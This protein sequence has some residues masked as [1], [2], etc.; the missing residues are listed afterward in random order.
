MKDSK[1][2]NVLQKLFDAEKAFRR[3]RENV[4]ADMSDDVLLKGISKEIDRAMAQPLSE[5]A[6]FR[7]MLCAE[8]LES[9]PSRESARLQLVILGHD[10][11]GIRVSAGE[12]LVNMLEDAW[13]DSSSACEAAIKEGTNL[14]ALREL[15][16]VLAESG[17]PAA[18]G[19]I[20]KLLTH[21]DADIVASAIE[22]LVEIGD[23]THR[24]EI[25]KLATDTRELSAIESEDGEA[26]QDS[27]TVGELAAEA[28]KILESAR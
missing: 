19:L 23:P 3:A 22:A 24:A 25:E 8:L 16:F 20:A 15:P 21:K 13:R 14:N 6:G 12:S 18:G 4:F 10:D 27:G 7:L 5:D 28:A 17:E 9:I 2:S 1:D 11:P 26:P